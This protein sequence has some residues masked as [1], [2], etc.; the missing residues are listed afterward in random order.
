MTKEEIDAALAAMPH[1]KTKPAPT[2]QA[3]AFDFGVEAQPDVEAERARRER[4]HREAWYARVE[5]SRV[6]LEG[7]LGATLKGSLRGAQTPCALLLGPTGCGKTSGALYLTALARNRTVVVRARDLSNA[8]RRHPLG[9]G[10]PPEI[11][12]AQDA[13]YLVIDDV[14]SEGND[15]HSIQDVL[16]VRYSSGRAVIVT[17]GLTMTE[18]TAHIGPAYVRRIV[19]Q[20]VRRADG[21]EFPVL[22][23]DCH[24]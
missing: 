12:R 23:V 4:L 5:A 7:R 14:G 18:L 20:H 11:A 24:D 22:V 17:T 9:Q 1:L 10:L 13:T 2:A 21:I 19:D 15:P 3:S 6:E 16:D 8:E